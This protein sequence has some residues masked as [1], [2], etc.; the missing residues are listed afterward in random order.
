MLL[1]KTVELNIKMENF[2]KRLHKTIKL[3]IGKKE[4]Y[5]CKPYFSKK[6]GGMVGDDFM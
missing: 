3:G 5:S 2:I 6:G 1:G 4:K